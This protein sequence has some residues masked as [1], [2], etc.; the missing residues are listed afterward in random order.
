VSLISDA[1]CPA[2]RLKANPS[3]V[4]SVEG[5]RTLVSFTHNENAANGM[6]ATF[7]ADKSTLSR[8]L[9]LCTAEKR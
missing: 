9:Q 7:V 2:Y 8:E 6:T 4:F 1:H 5:N 3:I